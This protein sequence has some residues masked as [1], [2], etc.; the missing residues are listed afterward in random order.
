M[1]KKSVIELIV[2]EEQQGNIRAKYGKSVLKQLSLK[3]TKKYGRGFSVDNLENMRKFYL[4]FG[5]RISGSISIYRR[6]E[7]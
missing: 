7:L 3:L 4:K 2:E 1:G 6:L 5:D